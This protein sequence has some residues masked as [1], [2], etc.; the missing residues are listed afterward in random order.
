MVKLSNVSAN[1]RPPDTVAPSSPPVPDTTPN[2][3]LLSYAKLAGPP[4]WMP[5]C[6]SVHVRVPPPVSTHVPLRSTV[7]APEPGATV[8]D[9]GALLE[10]ELQPA[11]N[12]EPT[13]ARSKG[14]TRQPHAGP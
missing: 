13:R 4:T 12:R 2:S 10:L 3:G 1:R 14:F 5:P 7:V 11:S 6:V 9:E 8:G